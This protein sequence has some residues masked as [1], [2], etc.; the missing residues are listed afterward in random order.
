MKTCTK[1]GIAKGE[2]E[3]VKNKH[4]KNGIEGICKKCRNDVCKKWRGANPE[5]SKLYQRSYY[6]A[7]SEKRKRRSKEWCEVNPEKAKERVSRWIKESDSYPTGLISLKYQIPKSEITPEMIRLKKIEL[8]NKRLLK[9]LKN[10]T[11]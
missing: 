4:C 7:N 1:C 5:K 9:Q 3:F 11:K 8:E 2:E 10:E 6:K